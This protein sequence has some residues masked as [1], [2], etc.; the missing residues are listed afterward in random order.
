MRTNL[1]RENDANSQVV[2]TVACMIK[3]KVPDAFT[4]VLNDGRAYDG[5]FAPEGR[6]QSSSKH[7][8]T[9]PCVASKSLIA[10][11]LHNRR[12]KAVSGVVIPICGDKGKIVKTTR[13]ANAAFSLAQRVV[14]IGRAARELESPRSALLVE[15]LLGTE[16][17]QC[18]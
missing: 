1:H 17:Q 11:D 5:D 13:E 9:I 15:P 18:A 12:C 8:P 7:Y 6:E 2:D 14:P 3:I 16:A 4:T 10:K